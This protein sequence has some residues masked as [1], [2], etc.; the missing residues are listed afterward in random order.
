MALVAKVK[1]SL[2]QRFQNSG[3]DVIEVKYEAL[4]THPESV[5]L[6]ILSRLSPSI[7]R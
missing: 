5:I 3:L 6:R 7:L 2:S 4:V 1:M